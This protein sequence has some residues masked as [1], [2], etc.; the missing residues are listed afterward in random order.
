MSIAVA[1]ASLSSAGYYMGQVSFSLGSI[2]AK[3][4]IILITN[5]KPPRCIRVSTQSLS[6]IATQGQG[7]PA[8]Q[9]V[10]LTNCRKARSWFGSVSTNWLSINPT[11]GTLDPNATQDVTVNATIAN[12]TAGTYT[13]IITFTSGPNTAMVSVTL[14]VQPTP[15]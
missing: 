13:G 8:A 14:T 11:N 2:T 3:M 6:F 5:A 1:S 10:T 12:L 9:T 4:D 15:S 7:D